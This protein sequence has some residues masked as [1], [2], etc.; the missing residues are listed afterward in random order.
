MITQTSQVEL[1]WMTRFNPRRAQY[2]ARGK[3]TDAATS[4]WVRVRIRAVAQPRQADAEQRAVEAT[5][6]H[7][8]EEVV[9]NRPQ[10]R[11]DG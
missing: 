5:G 3:G 10:G 9:G 11:A 6:Q 2:S 4:I 8:G 1:A 7:V